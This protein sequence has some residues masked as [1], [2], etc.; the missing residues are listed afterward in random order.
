M[1]FFAAQERARRKS[2]WLI[3]WFALALVAII[4]LTY[5]AS[6]VVVAL[7]HDPRQVVSFL[8]ILA[9][10]FMAYSLYRTW[11]TGD[12]LGF[13]GA[14]IVLTLL[15]ATYLWIEPWWLTRILLLWATVVIGCSLLYAPLTSN[16]FVLG[17]TLPIAY[18]ICLFVFFSNEVSGVA[19]VRMSLD[20]FL[21][22]DN[23]RFIWICLLV[24]GGIVTASLYRAWQIFRRG[25]AA[26]AEQL[27]GRVILRETRNMAEKRLLNVID[28]MSIAAGIPAPQAFVLSYEVSMNAFAAGLFPRDA[29]IGV[30][31]GLMDTMNRDELQGVIAHE[32]SHIVNGDS[33]LNLTLIC[34]LNGIYIVTVIGRSVSRVRGFAALFG[35]LL[36]GIGALAFFFGRVIQAAVS[37]EREYLADAFAVQF[38]R[39]PVGL[40]SA[41]KKFRDASTHIEHPQAAMANHLFFDEADA[42]DSVWAFLFATHPP[43][44]ERIRRLGKNFLES[45]DLEPAG[46]TG[47]LPSA[48]AFSLGGSPGGILASNPHAAMP[49]PIPVALPALPAAAVMGGIA[50]ELAQDSVVQAQILLENLPE[51]LRLE[52]SNVVGASGIACGLFISITQPDI[53][54]QQEALLPATALPVA[55]RLCAW[56]SYQPETRARYRLAWLDLVIPT[57]REAPKDEWQKLLGLIKELIRANGRISPSKFALYSLLQSALQPRSEREATGK[58]RPEQLDGDIASLL[59]LMAYAG[60][61]E[62]EAAK[63]AY[64]TA[65]AGSPAEKHL[66]FPD[67]KDFSLKTVSKAF[68]HL[69]LATPPYRKKILEACAVAAEHDGKITPVENELLRA[70]AQSLDC[71]AP[72]A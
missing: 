55:R 36:R 46:G 45:G 62:W 47:D 51:P 2:R 67:R 15:I 31:R 17:V 27:G 43:L 66:P 6:G 5:L 22:R 9:V 59:A 8:T 42:P 72:L 64:Q 34:L 35:F 33:R 29:V 39:N 1:D 20:L 53:Q 63:A 26:I 69:A 24:G 18:F 3:F 70:F 61:T 49:I 25:G 30:T 40:Q 14:V 10:P 37:R 13:V 7:W 11:Q 56:L 4:V 38:T 21:F 41:L 57:L 16:Y 54:L 44:N 12:G 60:H 32:I 23:R 52:A 50:G 68:G 19:E 48:P 58:L 28:E 71:P 65:L